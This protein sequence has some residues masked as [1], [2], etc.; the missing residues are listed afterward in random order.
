VEPPFVIGPEVGPDDNTLGLGANGWGVAAFALGFVLGPLVLILA[1]VLVWGNVRIH[2][3]SKA[4]FCV[5]VLLVMVSSFVAV[6]GVLGW[7]VLFRR[8]SRL[9]ARVAFGPAAHRADGTLVLVDGLVAM[10]AP[11]VASPLTGEPCVVGVLRIEHKHVNTRQ[12]PNVLTR[13]ASAPFVLADGESLINVT[14]NGALVRGWGEDVEAAHRPRI[15]AMLDER[16][17]SLDRKWYT[18]RAVERRVQP[19]QRVSVLGVL[20]TYADAGAGGAYRGGAARLEMVSTPDARLVITSETPDAFRRALTGRA[21]RTSGIVGGV[22]LALGYAALYLGY[23]LA[24][25]PR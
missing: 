7:L 3:E 9:L 18:V 5:G 13:E 19:G 25:A 4:I 8:S 17:M 20:R 16:G 24:S 14:P 1:P 22:L 15:D 2:D 6:T 11:A 12:A 23:T 10:D 21:W